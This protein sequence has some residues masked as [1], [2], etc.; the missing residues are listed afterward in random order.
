M[1]RDKKMSMKIYM[2]RHAESKG[3]L[4][5]IIDYNMPGGKDEN[6]L[7]EEGIRQAEELAKNL[8]NLHF[9][10]VIISP[11]RR[12]AQTL[13]PFLKDKRS[14]Q[15][16]TSPLTIERNAGIFSG[17]P[18]T[19]MKIYRE[20]NK[21]TDRISFKPQNGES[22]REVYERAKEFLAWLREE[23]AIDKKILI[24]GHD[25]FLRCLIIIMNNE[26]LEDFYTKENLKQATIL[27][28]EI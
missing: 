23:F 1:A 7:S 8:K 11:L 27:E 12:T 15:V 6:G 13:E 16:I 5:D 3:N 21:I 17:K 24:C 26:K 25:N 9:D 2:V 10:A 22:I 18:K 4:A 28:Y 20:E 19:A 14:M